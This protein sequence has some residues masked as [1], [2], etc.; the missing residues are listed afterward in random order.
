MTGKRPAATQA[1][2]PNAC[3]FCRKSQREVRKL[4]AGPEVMICDECIVLCVSIIDEQASPERFPTVLESLLSRLALPEVPDDLVEAA[5][6]AVLALAGDHTP[7]LR[8]IVQRAFAAARWRLALEASTRIEADRDTSDDIDRA[9]ALY[10][11]GDFEEAAA[12]VEAARPKS[13]I[14]VAL[15]ELNRV[16]ITLR[17]ESNLDVVSLE[18]MLQAVEAAAATLDDRYAG[19]LAGNRAECLVRLGRPA[20]ARDAL[21]ALASPTTLQRMLLGDAYLALGER[22]AALD[23]YRTAAASTSL[24]GA[25]AARRLSRATS[26]PYR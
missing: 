26:E 4:I 9:V 24:F 7:T 20:E 17:R 16:A 21:R 1:P 3:S 19:A 8:Q 13:P 15:V 10:E 23:A 5:S 11:L 18:R 6:G 2:R 25:E 14:Q 22:E 12:V